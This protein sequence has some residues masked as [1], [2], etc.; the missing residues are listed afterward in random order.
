MPPHRARP[1]IQPTVIIAIMALLAGGLVWLAATGWKMAVHKLAADRAAPRVAALPAHFTNSLG[2]VFIRVPHTEVLFSIWKTRVQDFASFVQSTGRDMH[3]RVFGLGPNGW[4]G[5]GATWSA[6]GFP[7]TPTCPVCCVNWEDAAAFC[8]WLTQ[9][10]RAEGDLPPDQGYRLPTDAEWTAAVTKMKFPWG[11]QWPPLPDM[12]NLG[13][14]EIAADAQA[15]GFPPLKGYRDSFAHTSPVGTFPANP[16]GL[17][18]MAGNVQEWCADWFRKE[19]N[20]EEFRRKHPQLNR[21]GGGQSYRV[22]RGSD[23]LDHDAGRIASA[24]HQ[25]YSPQVRMVTVGFRVVLAV[26][27]P[28]GAAQN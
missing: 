1:R 24:T 6:P 21:D 10:E 18:D 8:D 16:H 17:F 25:F 15:G 11:S 13:G 19:M 9:K 27:S 4:V 2:M 12:A 7:Q 26:D 3:G 5:T 20:S 22:L 14:E 23:W 28:P